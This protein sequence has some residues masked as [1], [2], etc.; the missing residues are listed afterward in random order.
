MVNKHDA[1]MS[2][3][4]ISP[5]TSIDTAT[6]TVSPKTPTNTL[7]IIVQPSTPKSKYDVGKVQASTDL[8]QDFR[9]SKSAPKKR[10]AIE[11]SLRSAKRLRAEYA[12]TRGEKRQGLATS[13]G[14]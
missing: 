6:T 9:N 8:N 14:R 10:V 11:K 3:Y 1:E 5:L 4:D 7:S 12:R 2:S 13:K